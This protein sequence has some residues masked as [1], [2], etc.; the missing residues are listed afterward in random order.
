MPESDEQQTFEWL[1]QQAEFE[2]Q[3]KPDYAYGCSI[4]GCAGMFICPALLFASLYFFGP[5]DIDTP[6]AF[7]IELAVLLI[8]SVPVGA[9]LGVA[10]TV[11]VTALRHRLRKR[12]V[13][14]HRS[15]E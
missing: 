1:K 11:G 4:G 13:Q 2:Q 9:V 14:A 3:R 5:Q 12:K 8:L 15:S 6:F 7:M 10:L